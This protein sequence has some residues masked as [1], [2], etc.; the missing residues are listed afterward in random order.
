MAETPIWPEVPDPDFP[1]PQ[2]LENIGPLDTENPP[3]KGVRLRFQWHRV[4][5]ATWKL[6]NDETVRVPASHGQW[7]GYNTAKAVAWAIQLCPGEWLA[8]GRDQTSGP[9]SLNTTKAVAMAMA[10]GAVGDYAI[11]DSV[12]HLNGL[13]ARLLN[14]GGVQS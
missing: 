6:G 8:R 3:H 5:D 9:S 4:N 12:R 1:A 2:P 13:T 11:R 7:G 14:R 10:K